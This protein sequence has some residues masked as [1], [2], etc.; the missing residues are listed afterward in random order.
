MTRKSR[1]SRKG[2]GTGVSNVIK[3][4]WTSVFDREYAPVLHWTIRTSNNKRH[5]HIE[6]ILTPNVNFRGT[7]G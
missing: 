4:A 5:M 6:L 2:M 3:K 7:Q 1:Q